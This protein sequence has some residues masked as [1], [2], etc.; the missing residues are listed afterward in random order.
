MYP[1]LFCGAALGEMAVL[2]LEGSR[3]SANRIQE[4]GFEFMDTDLKTTLQ[5][6]IRERNQLK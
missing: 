3:V 4:S 6:I 1:D 2:V 5:R